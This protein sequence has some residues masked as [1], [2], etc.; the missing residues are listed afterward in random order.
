MKPHK[1]DGQEERTRGKVNA[2]LLIRSLER[3]LLVKVCSRLVFRARRS[4]KLRPVG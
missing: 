4:G 3:V 2:N 1:S